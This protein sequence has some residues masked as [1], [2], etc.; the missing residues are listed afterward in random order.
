MRVNDS[1]RWLLAAAAVLTAGVAVGQDEPTASTPTM[2]TFVVIDGPAPALPL[3]GTVDVL[4]GEGSVLGAVVTGKPYSAES[5]TETTQIL[6]DG[7]RIVHTNRARVY[8][9]SAGRSR[10]EQTLTGVGPW[11]AAN[12]DPVTIVSIDDPVAR[13]S[14]VLEQGT[15]TARQVRQYRLA[16]GGAV[17]GAGPNFVIAER[18]AP[19]PPLPEPA[20]TVTMRRLERGVTVGFPPSTVSSVRVS[21]SADVETRT[22]ELGEQVIEGVLARGVRETRTIPAGAIGNERPIEVVTEQ[23]YSDEL[24]ALMVRRTSD[25]RFG[26]TVYRLVG[27]VQGEPSPELFEVPEDY[28]VLRND[29]AIEPAVGAFGAGRVLAVRPGAKPDGE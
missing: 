9:D 1:S 23:W 8:R 2:N 10:R 15:R 13:T 28:D 11:S 14:Y 3:G 25:P 5:I 4:R 27:V 22:E 26:E 21:P 19:P 17:P 12:G 16:D 6:A 20:P 24:E 7:N 29:A 18:A